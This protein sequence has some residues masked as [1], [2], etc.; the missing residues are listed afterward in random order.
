LDGGGAQSDLRRVGRRRRAKRSAPG[1]TAAARNTKI[2]I[3]WVAISKKWYQSVDDSPKGGNRTPETR[4]RPS[5]TRSTVT[6][7]EAMV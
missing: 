5:T 3:P 2:L 6:T 4:L 1:W 7:S